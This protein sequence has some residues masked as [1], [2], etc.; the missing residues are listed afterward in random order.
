LFLGVADAC[1]VAFACVTVFLWHNPFSRTRP[2]WHLEQL[3]NAVHWLHPD[4]HGMHMLA[5]AFLNLP[6][7]HCATHAPELNADFFASQVMHS[8]E[9]APP[10]VRQDAWQSVQT[11]LTTVLPFWS[12]CVILFVYLF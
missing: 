10:H 3:P 5:A 1:I 2:F 7:G 6:A 4:E 9:P 12:F 8:V 11:W